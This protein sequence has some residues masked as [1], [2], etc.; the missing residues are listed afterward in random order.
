MNDEDRRYA[1]LRIEVGDPSLRMIVWREENDEAFWILMS[2]GVSVSGLDEV[3]FDKAFVEVSW[4]WL[5]LDL[6]IHEC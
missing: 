2:L 3:I 1:G 4:I 6:C 5:L